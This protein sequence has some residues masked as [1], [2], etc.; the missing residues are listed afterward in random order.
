VVVALFAVVVFIFVGLGLDGGMLYVERRQLQNVADAACLAGATE[1]GR[2]ILSEVETMTGGTPAPGVVRALTLARALLAEPA[3]AERFLEEALRLALRAAPWYRARVDLALGTWLRRRRRVAES[4]RPLSAAQAAFDALGARAWA[5]RA[6]QE[7]AATGQQPR[8]R[9]PDG[10]ARLSAQELQIARL[11]AQGLS[12]REIG[13]RLYLSHR[14]VA[15]HL[16]RVFPKLGVSS[17][18]QLHLVLPAA[19]GMAVTAS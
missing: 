8:R 12:N 6:G 1:D 19:E 14:T 3:D 16:Y 5:R 18:A 17:R 13:Q 11:A 9:Q 7:L 2:E 10:W 15:S 4:R